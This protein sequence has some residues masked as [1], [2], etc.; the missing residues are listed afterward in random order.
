MKDPF[1]I[2]RAYFFSKKLDLD[3]MNQG[4]LLLIGENN[5]RAFSK[6]KQHTSLCCV[7]SANWIKSKNMLL[8]SIEADRFVYNMVRCIVGTLIDLGLKKINLKDFSK[9]ISSYNRSKSGYSVP[10]HGLYLM[11]VKY[12]KHYN[13]EKV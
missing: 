10:A 12:P 9:I 13:I 8:F 2:N 7:N 11:N 6:A 1:L 3:I 4:T 5:F